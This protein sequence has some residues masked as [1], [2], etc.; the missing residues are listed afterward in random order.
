[1]FDLDVVADR[2]GLHLFDD[3]LVEATALGGRVAA[4]GG[5]EAPRSLRGAQGQAP[6]G[7]DL[8]DLAFD[9]AAAFLVG[10]A[11][12]ALGVVALLGPARRGKG[13]GEQSSKK[14]GAYGGTP[15][16]RGES[17]GVYRQGGGDA[18]VGSGGE[19]DTGGRFWPLWNRDSTWLP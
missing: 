13:T 19:S 4:P 14:E 10:L 12:F 9:G 3:V 8:G 11:A 6:L 5:H 15:G 16:R 1:M 17:R 7:R 2:E 18:R